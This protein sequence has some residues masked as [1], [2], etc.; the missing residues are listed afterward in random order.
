MLE[1]SITALDATAVPTAVEPMSSALSSPTTAVIPSKAFNS[2]A[3]LVT[4][5][6]IFSSA[7]VLVTPSKILS[8]AAVLVTPS[9]MFN[10]SGVEVIAVLLAAA[11]TGIV[12]L[13]LG[14]LIVRSAV[15]STIVSVVSC[16][17][18]VAVSYTHLTLPTKRIV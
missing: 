9:N 17:S 7:A 14:K 1:S 11:S 15:G 2:A 8:S 4:P 6:S 12:P 16:A 18:A 5:S 3:V 13:W 10:S